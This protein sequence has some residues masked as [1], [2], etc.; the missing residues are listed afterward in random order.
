MVCPYKGLATFDGDDAE[1]FFGRERLVAELVAR[2]V[3][4]PLL[5]VV[6]PSGSGKSSVVR[7]GL[8]PALAGGVL[9]GSD[10]W[11]RA[12]IRPGEHP[13]RELRARAR[14]RSTSRRGVLVVDQ[15]E[16]LF[17][18]CQDERERGEFVAALVRLPRPSAAASSCS[19]CAPTSTAAAPPTRSCRALL[20]A[21]H[22]L[23]G[24]MSPD[25]LRRAIERPA[26]RVGLSVEPELVDALLA[27]RRG[28]SRARCRCCRPRCSSSGAGATAGACGSPAYAAQRRRP[29]RGRAAGRGRLRRGSTPA[30]Q[31]VARD[32]LLRLAG[33]G[34]GGAIVRRRDRR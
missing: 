11:A 13:L 29:G 15:F 21:N 5:G 22:V 26:R 4:A 1:Y 24:P 8:L 17:T 2:L 20:G 27:R 25:E 16:E 12:L 34:E 18:A 6:G 19:P 33:E 7:A 31:A 28:P 14:A 23:V 30:Q 10:G 32:V 3:G 9:P